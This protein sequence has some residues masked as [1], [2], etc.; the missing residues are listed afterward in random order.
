MPLAAQSPATH[1][2]ISELGG[3]LR[4]ALPM[5][6]NWGIAFFLLL[7]VGG[8]S[9]GLLQ[10]SRAL[11]QK[12]E[13]FTLNA[14]G[15]ML[16]GELAVTF[17]VLRVFGGWYVVVVD[18]P[19]CTVRRQIFGVGWTEKYTTAEMR[20]LRFQP[21]EGYGKGRQPSRILFD[22]GKKAIRLGSDLDESEANSLIALIKQ[23][24]QI[25]GG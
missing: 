24:A 17:V 25:A 6:R 4:I 21:A 1:S 23:R 16:L 12:F 8:W 3:T 13:W 22:H 7:W 15:I 14:L 20:N 2:T 18:P 5:E 19:R 10:I 11:I 9:Y